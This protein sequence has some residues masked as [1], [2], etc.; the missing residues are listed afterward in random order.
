VSAAATFSSILFCVP[1]SRRT[2][3][4]SLNDTASVTWRVR[5]N[6]QV[7]AIASTGCACCPRS[8]SSF[9]ALYACEA[10]PPIYHHC[11]QYPRPCARENQAQH[12][13]SSGG[14]PTD[15]RTAGATAVAPTLDQ[16]RCPSPSRSW[17]SSGVR[18]RYCR[19]DI[20][21]AKCRSRVLRG[22][23]SASEMGK[24]LRMV[25]S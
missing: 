24:L 4:R 2:R 15:R 16:A 10:S 8:P 23:V 12:C 14:E 13:G 9:E 20:S 1:C 11:A 25:T 6:H 22:V 18:I 19:C 3:R 7:E 5:A 21:C 17:S